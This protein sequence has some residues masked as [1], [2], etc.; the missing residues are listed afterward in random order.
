MLLTLGLIYLG[1]MVTTRDA[2]LSVHD[3]PTSLGTFNPPGW[4]EDEEVRL[5]HGHR[6]YGGLVGFVILSATLL[7][8]LRRG[9][10]KFLPHCVVLLT[11]VTIQGLM[12]G[13]RVTQV[14][15]E[16]AVVHGVLAQLFLVG[17]V[18]LF[19]RA[20]GLVAWGKNCKPGRGFFYWCAL[21]LPVV[22]LG[23]LLVAA[24]MRHYKAGM[25]IPDFPLH[26]G[27]LI[28]SLTNFYVNIHFAH[29][30][31]GYLIAL[32][33]LV[34]LVSSVWQR[35]SVWV[36][37]SAVLF[38]VV[39]LQIGLGAW[40]VLSGR[41]AVPTTWHVMNGA[42]LLMLS[43]VTASLAYASSTS[44]LWHDVKTK[45]HPSIEGLEAT[46]A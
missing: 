30:I 2:G 10:R 15:T 28:P 41:G 20:S 3:W 35:S 26:M 46:R 33:I 29:R 34:M 12:G 24:I 4:W 43:V 17:L 6:L 7:A 38:L 14:S 37:W 23:Q 32:M 19:L 45:R 27:Q 44:R 9:S 5:E 42:L 16:L 1:G 22:L 21:A 31:L 8:W 25:A 39:A 18:L 40:S 11:M 36:N 13:L